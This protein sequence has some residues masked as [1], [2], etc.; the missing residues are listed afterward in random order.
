VVFLFFAYND[1]TIHPF[2]FRDLRAMLISLI[3]KLPFME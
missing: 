1:A 3:G 2:D